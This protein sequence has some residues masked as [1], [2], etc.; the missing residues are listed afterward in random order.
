MVSKLFET[1]SEC[2]QKLQKFA[3]NF[4]QNVCFV[5]KICE[6]FVQNSAGK[7]VYKMFHDLVLQLEVI[8]AK[9]RLKILDR[10]LPS[11]AKMAMKIE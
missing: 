8:L 7:L 3:R 5:E 1:I 2:F 10:D 9:S 4:C 11:L 6:T